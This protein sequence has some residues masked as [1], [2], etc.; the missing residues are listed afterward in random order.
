MKK[1][2]KAVSCGIIPIFINK[3]GEKEFFIVLQN[4]GNWSFPKGHMEQ[5]ETFLDTAKRELYEESGLTCEKIDSEK[6]FTHSYTIENKDSLVYK[7]VHYFIGYLDKKEPI[8]QKEEVK[9]FCW[10]SSDEVMHK[11]KFENIK[12]LFSEIVSTLDKTR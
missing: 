9:D 1:I 5:G 3:D 8:L 6:M 7:T 12:S 10:C 4:N 11:L 2:R